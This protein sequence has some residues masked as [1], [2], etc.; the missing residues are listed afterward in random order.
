MWGS[1][2]SD[3]I[4]DIGIPFTIFGTTATEKCI[5]KINSQISKPFIREFFLEITTAYNTAVVP[6]NIIVFDA[7][8][9]R[10]YLITA[11]A[12]NKLGNEVM[13]T[14][15]VGY[16]CNSFGELQRNNEI[17]WNA[18]TYQHTNAWTTILDP[19]PALLSEVQFGAMSE[20]HDEDIGEIFTQEL[21][22]YLP[23][24]IG[25]ET[26]DRYIVD[27]VNWQIGRIETHRFSGCDVCNV[28]VDSRK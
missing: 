18:Q 10:Y 13:T 4:D 11:N 25:I 23:H 2:V 15:I 1:D 9:G 12:F 17:G 21:K 3:I 8:D 14:E 22:L 24:S 16:K 26:N 5:T 28:E 20:I 19:C 6:G 7:P 27:G